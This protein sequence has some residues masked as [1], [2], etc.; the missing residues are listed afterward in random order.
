VYH[1]TD[2]FSESHIVS[3]DSS[4]IEVILD[5]EYVVLTVVVYGNVRE[6]VA[7]TGSFMVP[8]IDAFYLC[9]DADEL[10]PGYSICSIKFAFVGKHW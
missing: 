10:I 9:D 6:V 7:I 1:N 4:R 2:E 8:S 3:L 5:W